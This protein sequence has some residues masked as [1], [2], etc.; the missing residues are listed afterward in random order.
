MK[1]RRVMVPLAVMAAAA[2]FVPLA[3]SPAAAATGS[4]C[5]ATG[6]RGSWWGQWES[7]QKL[8]PL[9]LYVKDY[10]ADSHHVGVRLQTENKNGTWKTWSWHEVYGGNGAEQTWDTHAYDS[11]WIVR[12]RVQAAVMEGTK[13]L[14]A[15][16]SDWKTY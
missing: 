15:C 16:W 12:A 6:V 11:D 14:N 1:F 8:D 13:V 4:M 5:D 10:K 3:A 9:S 7:P 2:A